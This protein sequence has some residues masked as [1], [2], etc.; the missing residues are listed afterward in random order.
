MNKLIVFISIISALFLLIGCSN[1]TQTI[2]S[3]VDIIG[4]DQAILMS[5]PGHADAV[6]IIVIDNK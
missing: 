2:N 6:Q 5:Y 4:T 3:E 1:P